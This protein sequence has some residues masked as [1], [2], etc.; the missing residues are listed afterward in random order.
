[1]ERIEF[2][3]ASSV[4]KS[5]LFDNML[6][7]RNSKKEWVTSEEFTVQIARNLKIYPTVI[8]KRTIGIIVLK[9]N[10]LREKHNRIARRLLGDY[11]EKVCIRH[12]GTY[13]ALTNMI[14]DGAAEDCGLLSHLPTPFKKNKYLAHCHQCIIEMLLL[15]FFDKN[16]TVVFND[17]SIIRHNPK[18]SD[19]EA[20]MK[21]LNGSMEGDLKI[22]PSGII[23]CNLSLEENIERRLSRIHSGVIQFTEKDLTEQEIRNLC[24]FE[25][26]DAKQKAEVMKQAGV[27]VLEVDMAGNPDQ[28]ANHVMDFIKRVSFQPLPKHGNAGKLT[29]NSSYNR[30][31]PNK[32]RMHRLA[33]K[34]MNKT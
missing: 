17:K 10:I 2:I 7:K 16:K 8:S 19:K 5:T 32:T 13:N 11:Q 4:G 33:Q 18:T 31:Y 23:F 3:G 20:Y 22:N 26:E 25:I 14:M 34:V 29:V 9:G 24:R 1:M 12:A 28:N 21:A 6:S 15:E 27:P 30:S